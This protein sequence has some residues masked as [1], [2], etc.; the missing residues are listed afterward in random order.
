[1]TWSEIWEQLT[2]E[3]LTNQ[4]ISNNQP[5]QFID[6]VHFFNPANFKEQKST[7]VAG[8]TYDVQAFF[9]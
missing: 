9:Y 7:L 6:F 1:M 5:D 3:S 2:G 8:G 4:A